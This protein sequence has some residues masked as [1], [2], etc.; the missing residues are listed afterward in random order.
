MFFIEWEKYLQ[1]F[2]D[3]IFLVFVS[4]SFNTSVS[5]ACLWWFM[6]RSKFFSFTSAISS[7][8]ATLLGDDMKLGTVENKILIG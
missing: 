7:V 2:T 3:S 8:I 4:L 6:F 1:S 5:D